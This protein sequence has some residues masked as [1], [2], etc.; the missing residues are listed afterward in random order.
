MGTL[1][2]GKVAPAIS[3]KTTDGR[4]VTLAE[5]LKKGPVLAAFFKVNCPTCQFTMPFVERIHATYSG[6]GFTVFG[7]SQNDVSESKEFMKQFGVNFPV[8]VDTAGYPASNQYG[9]TNVPSLFLISPDRRIQMSS[10]G[11]TKTDM[12]SIASAAARASGK[13]ESPLFKPG[14]VVPDHKPG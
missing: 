7:V 1:T 10:V 2:A 4:S 8:L 6:S 14:E 13:P 9:L 5:A 3:L 11:F 12:E